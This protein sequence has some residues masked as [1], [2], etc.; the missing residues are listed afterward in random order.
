MENN[1]PV[2]I[3]FKGLYENKEKHYIVG[4]IEEN[5]RYAVVVTLRGEDVDKVNAAGDVFQIFYGLT[6]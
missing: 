4:I 3:S 1:N 5:L 2:K 6:E